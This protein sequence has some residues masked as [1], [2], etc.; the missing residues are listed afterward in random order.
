MSPDV[1]VS[2]RGLI[3]VM[4]NKMNFSIRSHT[5]ILLWQGIDISVDRLIRS[6]NKFNIYSVINA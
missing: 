3:N 1:T 4:N 5:H 6:T 2:V